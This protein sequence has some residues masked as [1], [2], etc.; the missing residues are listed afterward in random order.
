[1]Y[2]LGYVNPQTGILSEAYQKFPEPLDNGI[3]GA[4]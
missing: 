3:R 2:G 4:L 1:M